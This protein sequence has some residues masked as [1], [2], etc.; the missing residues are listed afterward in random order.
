[1]SD[2]LADDDFVLIYPWVGGEC[3]HRIVEST[4]NIHNEARPNMRT[5]CGRDN[6]T[7]DLHAFRM[8]EVR[9]AGNLRPCRKCFPDT[10]FLG[11]H[12]PKRKRAK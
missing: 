3:Y 2:P 9:K 1:M 4:K 5:G 11:P 6:R 8:N 7:S 12:F 10:P